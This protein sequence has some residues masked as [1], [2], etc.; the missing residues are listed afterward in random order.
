MGDELGDL[1]Y[2]AQQMSIVLEKQYKAEAITFAIQDGKYAGQ[3][4][5]HVHVHIIPR[6]ANDFEKNDDIYAELEKE[7]SEFV[8][9]IGVEDDARRNTQTEE[10]M[11]SEAAS[12]RHIINDAAT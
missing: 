10:E 7:S 1:W 12:Y 8:Q 3:T 9:S 4:I 5:N 11:I 6:F 2:L